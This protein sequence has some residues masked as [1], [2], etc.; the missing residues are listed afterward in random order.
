MAIIA[1]L[2]VLIYFEG[3]TMKPIKGIYLLSLILIWFALSSCQQ[4]DTSKTKIS[5]DNVSP[6][7]F[8]RDGKDDLV[9]GVQDE[10]VGNKDGAG[11]AHILYG[12]NNNLVTD[13]NQIFHLDSNG[14]RGKATDFDRFASALAVGDFNND[15][16][17]DLA[18]GVDLDE[19]SGVNNAGAVNVIYGHN[20]GLR[21]DGNQRWTQNSPGIKNV[22]EEVD[23][24]GAALA[25]GDFNN[26]GFDDLAVGVPNED[27]NAIF[28]SGAVNIIYGS[29]T[30]LSSVNN[31]FLHQGKNAVLD[32]AEQSDEFGSSLA[33]GDFNADGY[34]DLAVGVPH[35]SI[36]T[37]D[38]NGAVNV[39]YGSATGLKTSNDEFWHQDIFLVEGAAE[40]FDFFGSSLAAC[41]FNGD[42]KDDLAIGVPNEAVGSIVSAGAVNIIYGSNKGLATK[43]NS[44][45]DQG[46]AGVGS[47]ETADQFG[48]SLAGGDFDGDNKCD[49]AVGIP[50]EDIEGSTTLL[51]AGA[52]GILYGSAS[53]ID[54][55]GNAG[56][57]LDSPNVLGVARQFDQFGFSLAVG[58][59]GGDNR[60]DLAVSA[61]QKDVQGVISAGSVTVLYGTNGGL[62]GFGSQRWHQ[63]N[64]N[65]AETP[66]SNDRFGYT[67]AAGR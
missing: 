65:I 55:S 54:S 48:H 23:L 38:Q 19:V 12:S 18:I 59:F 67:L 3:G 26:D 37:L 43:N 21:S 25:V 28:D 61:P 63:G 22:A 36:D 30:G 62:T 10:A 34:E 49:L 41:D 20:S 9:V 40:D 58:D 56:F 64:A 2:A 52:I 60:Y 50:F 11:I 29:A 27:H 51:D 14:I 33:A 53:G 44:I 66:E 16:K 4:Q 31:Q 1:P 6:L 39:F 32:T 35:E 46:T 13:N 57:T 15:G 47:V 45:W 8:N 24:F 17:N 7:D 5:E 42:S